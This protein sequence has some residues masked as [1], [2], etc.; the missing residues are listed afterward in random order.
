MLLETVLNGAGRG[1]LPLRWIA[2][3]TT[4][5]IMTAITNHSIASVHDDSSLVIVEGG[6]V[7]GRHG[8]RSWL[9]RLL[10][11]S[12]MS[13]STTSSPFSSFSRRAGHQSSVVVAAAAAVV[14]TQRGNVR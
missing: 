10:L 6:A 14:V 11:L 12:L 7:V 13:Q 1:E 8:R 9:G 3:S 5:L 4:N 2:D